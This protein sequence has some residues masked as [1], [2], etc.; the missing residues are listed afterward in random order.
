MTDEPRRRKELGA[1]STTEGAQ[2]ISQAGQLTGE[3]PKIE[4]SPDETCPFDLSPPLPPV[5]AGTT[6]GDFEGSSEEGDPVGDNVG[7]RII[8][9]SSQTISRIGEGD[10]SLIPGG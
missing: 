6:I 10:I 8:L 5:G 1:R 7:S 9:H 4:L 2:L 3:S